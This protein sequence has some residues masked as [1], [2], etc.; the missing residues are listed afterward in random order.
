MIAEILFKA[1][2]IQGDIP[3]L[4]ATSPLKNDYIIKELGLT[5][6]TYYRK[7]K[8]KD[9]SLDEMIKLMHLI[10]PHEVDRF[11]LKRELE[12]GLEEYEN[13]ELIDHD[14][15]VRNVKQTL[16]ENKVD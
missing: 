15:F 13:G 1:K 8:K 9:F 4:I 16:N 2:D 3:R 10:C 7:V 14:T 6:S 5:P 12:L 11:L